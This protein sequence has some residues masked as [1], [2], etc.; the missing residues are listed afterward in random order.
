VRDQGYAWDNCG[1]WTGCLSLIVLTS[2]IAKKEKKKKVAADPASWGVV[3][4]DADQII[5]WLI[6]Y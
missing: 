1:G 6:F 3:K 5:V 2:R 4:G